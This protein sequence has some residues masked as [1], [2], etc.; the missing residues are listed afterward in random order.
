MSHA[1]KIYFSGPLIRRIERDP[2]GH[3]PSK[4][5]GWV[6][7]WAQLGGTTL[8]TWD[9]KAIAE[10]SKNGKEVPP[11]YINMTDAFVQVLGS[12]TVP[13]TPENPIA[14]KYTNV[15]TLN[16]AGSNLLLFACP[17]TKSLICWAAALR[18]SAWEKSRLEEIYTAHLIRITLSGE[19]CICF[20]ISSLLMHL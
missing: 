14:Q 13:P 18:L 3:K 19:S 10:A 16:T 7:I 9:M 11:S 20:F 6:E 8:S 1:H 2:S 4:D 17:D 15:L 5:E 12:V